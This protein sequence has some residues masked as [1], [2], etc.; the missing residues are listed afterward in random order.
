M[1]KIKAAVNSFLILL[2]SST[3]FSIEKK[4]PFLLVEKNGDQ[5]ETILSYNTKTLAPMGSLLK[6]FAAWYLLERGINSE[7]P[8]F[9]PPRR[10]Q[11]KDLRCWTPDGHGAMSLT[12]ALAHSCNYYFLSRFLGLNL[13]EYEMWLRNN[14]NW[15]EKVKIKTPENVYGFNLSKN[16]NIKMILGM[17]TQLISKE[18]NGD[19]Q[20]KVVF[21]GLKKT[22]QGTLY[23]FCRAL[24]TLHEFRFIAGKT[25][26]SEHHGKNY[27]IAFLYLEHIPKKR[28]IILLCYEKNK[29]GAQ[30]AL[31]AIKILHAYRKRS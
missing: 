13:Q 20:A 29:M 9:C 11:S 28:K 21:E 6:P 18:E 24:K 26:T 22:C 14:F 17:Y 8:I 27:G 19:A 15:P 2:F 1:R 23:D 4:A 5:Y 25:G 31:N 3:T 30:V 10:K 7:Q 16:F 12:D